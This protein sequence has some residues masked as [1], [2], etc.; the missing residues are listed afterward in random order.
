MRNV[1]TFKEK[2]GNWFKYKTSFSNPDL[3]PE[4]NI[5]R[6][7]ADLSRSAYRDPANIPGRNERP[8]STYAERRK[9]ERDKK[10]RKE[11]QK[12]KPPVV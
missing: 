12:K 11:S 1:E 8:F 6:N 4:R 2:C 3:A 5:Q 9:R 10:P 7:P